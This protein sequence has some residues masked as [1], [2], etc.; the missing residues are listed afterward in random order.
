MKPRSLFIAACLGA[1]VGGQALAQNRTFTGQYSFGDSLSDNGNLYALSGRTAPPAPYY[2]G[3]FSNGPVFVELLGNPLAAGASLPGQGHYVNFAVGGASAVVANGLPTLSQQI[4]IYRQQGFAAT[5]T[6][7]FTVL[8]GANDLLGALTSPSAATNPAIVDSAA[9]AVAQAVATN[10]QTLVSLGAKNIV[11]GGLPNLGATPRA[12]GLGGPSGGAA[13][14]GLRATTAFNNELQTRLQAIAASA[15][16]V[17]L[18]YVD[19]RGFLDRVGTDYRALGFNNATSAYLAPAAQG[20]GAGDPNGYVFWDDIH[21]TTH[22]HALLAAFVLEQLNPEPVLGFAS[23]QGM[24]A[25]ALQGVASSALDTRMSQVAASTRHVGRA[26]VF[27]TYNYED[28]T[29]S[30]DG[31]RP[32]FDFDAHVATAGVDLQASDGIFLGG[33]VNGGRLDARV[34]DHRGSFAV[35]NGV[36]TLYGIWRGGPVALLLDGSYGVLR[37]KNIKRTTALGG[38]PT[39]GKTSGDI[40][41][42]GIKALWSLDWRAL[43]VRPWLGL[44]TTRV[45]LDPYTEKEIPGL[46]MDFGKQDANSSTGSAGVDAAVKFNVGRRDAR[47]DVRAAWHGE[48]GSDTRGLSGRLADNFTRPTAISVEDGD[49]SGV[50]LGG[51]ATIFFAKNSSASLGYTADIRVHDRVASRATVSIQTGF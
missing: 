34:K 4:G 15:T 49:G 26:D 9:I 14:L 37:V 24:A 36:G 20:G 47:F 18:I 8:I 27:A 39:R 50:E 31:W 3:R 29:R 6:D 16:D 22:T 5:P 40:W 13:A 1:A 2:N 21:P 35:E 17:N 10:V 11:V 30:R 38:L 23:T 44:R 19:L 28:A 51:A 48:I 46:A 12:L 42:G 7:L 32:K 45:Q 33:A 25:L 43:N 41:G